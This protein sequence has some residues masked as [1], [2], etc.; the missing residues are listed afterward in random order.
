MLYPVRR[1]STRKCP[2][3]SEVHF[4]Y[5]SKKALPCAES[6]WR[7]GIWK[8]T[9]IE[10]VSFASAQARPWF[11][12]LYPCSQKWILCIPD[13]K[14]QA[15]LK[16]LKSHSS[17]WEHTVCRRNFI[18]FWKTSTPLPVALFFPFNFDEVEWFMRSCFEGMSYYTLFFFSFVG[19]Q[20]ATDQLCLSAAKYV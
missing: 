20:Y 9:K 3:W 16:V 12:F 17:I 1:H 8:H 13:S 4:H 7:D 5:P 2:E 14:N 10:Y 6:R 15:H 18:L 19:I 11:F